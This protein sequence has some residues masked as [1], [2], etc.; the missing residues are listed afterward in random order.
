MDNTNYQNQDEN[1]FLNKLLRSAGAFSAFPLL[2]IFFANFT[3]PPDYRN[4][5]NLITILVFPSNF[6]LFLVWFFM[7]LVLFFL[8]IKG[9]RTKYALLIFGIYLIFMIVLLYTGA[10]RSWGALGFLVLLFFQIII[11][12]PLILIFSLIAKLKLKQ[13]TIII[14][15]IVG[16]LFLLN[17]MLYSSSFRSAFSTMSFPIGDFLLRW[18]VGII[19]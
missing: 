5:I 19:L 14:W 9:G 2:M 1:K 17:I 3:I 15:I 18:V 6:L 7:V 8:N 10:D 4:I 12:I 11:L 13:Q 16:V